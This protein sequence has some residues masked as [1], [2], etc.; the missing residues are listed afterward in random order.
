MSEKE[1]VRVKA[2]RE[3]QESKAVAVSA[4]TAMAEGGRGGVPP[5]NMLAVI[6]AAAA[7]PRVDVAKMQ[8]LLTMQRELED[9][10]AQKAFTVAFIAMQKEIPSIQRDGKIEIRAKDSQGGRS[11]P[12]QQSTPY[13]TFNGIMKAIEKPLRKHGFSLTFATEP[14]TDGR[15]LVRGILEHEGGHSRTTAFPLPAET[16]G[17]K[18]NVQGWGSAMSY[19]RRYCT[20]A[21]VNIV[22]HDPRDADTD[23]H[24]GTFRPTVEGGLTEAVEVPTLSRAQEQELLAVMK[25]CGVPEPRFCEQFGLSQVKDL[26]VDL[27]ETAKKRCRD[28]KEKQAH[29]SR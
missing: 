17:S 27:F 20:M 24:E 6:A 28:Y 10:E 5:S 9:R 4:G 3:K 22:S 26:S 1:R 14:T 15:I 8:A 13:A 21:L 25:D 23:G 19:G 7:D 12:V 11:G 18:N 29:G 2:G 16:S